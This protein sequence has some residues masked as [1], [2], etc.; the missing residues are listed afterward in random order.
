MDPAKPA[1]QFLKLRRRAADVLM[2]ERTVPGRGCAED[3]AAIDRELWPTI[4]DALRQCQRGGGKLHPA[5]AA[6]LIDAIEAG[7]DGRLPLAWP[8]PSGQC[9]TWRYEAAPEGVAS[10]YRT[11]GR[12]GLLRDKAWTRTVKTLFGVSER[13]IDNWTLA[14]PTAQ[15]RDGEHVTLATPGLTISGKVGSL[16][17]VLKRELAGAAERYRTKWHKKGG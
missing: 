13:Q 9:A 3:L 12:A 2:A 6:H 7:L 15:R 11:A 14:F 10:L 5:I 16:D 1:E 4:L 17:A 8:E